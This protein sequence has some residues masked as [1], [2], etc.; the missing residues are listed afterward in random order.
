MLKK[1]DKRAIKGAYLDLNIVGELQVFR[2]DEE[3]IKGD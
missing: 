1:G 2:C 3:K